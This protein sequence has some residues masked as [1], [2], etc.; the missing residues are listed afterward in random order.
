M[1]AVLGGHVDIAPGMITHSGAQIKAGRSAAYAVFDEKRSP[2]FPD[3]PHS[4][5]QGLNMV[6][7]N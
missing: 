7:H 6:F 4:Q 5:G 1:M 3:V 2:E